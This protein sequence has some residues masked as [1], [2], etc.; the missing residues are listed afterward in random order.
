MA[1]TA[2]SAISGSDLSQQNTFKAI[3][4]T[5]YQ[6][7][8]NYKHFNA[9]FIGEL[10][11]QMESITTF[12]VQQKDKAVKKDLNPLS[13]LDFND[14]GN[15][16]TTFEQIGQ[17]LKDQYETGKDPNSWVPQLYADMCKARTLA[18]NNEAEMKKEQEKNEELMKQIE[19]LERD[20]VQFRRDLADRMESNESCN[21]EAE[22]R[23]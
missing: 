23:L 12:F 11:N 20:L 13:S 14:E 3:F 22:R 1:A 18:S 15:S 2:T 8:Y 21:M 4:Y 5:K 19:T 10:V 6:P 17:H 16:G 9:D 7:S